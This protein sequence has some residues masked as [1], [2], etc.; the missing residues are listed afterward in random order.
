MRR[1][2]RSWRTSVNGLYLGRFR[3][4]GSSAWHQQQRDFFPWPSCAKDRMRYSS[5]PRVCRVR[6]SRRSR[7]RS[8]ITATSHWP[9]RGNIHPLG[10]QHRSLCP[11]SSPT[12]RMS[13]MKTIR[14]GSMRKINATGVSTLMPVLLARSNPYCTVE[15]KSTSSIAFIRSFSIA[16][17]S[18]R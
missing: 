6:A 13:P 12:Q 8:S 3:I 1:T 5:A 16:N 17:S 14:P 7:L 18:Y 4:R 2:P 15:T 11:L 10:F 9:R